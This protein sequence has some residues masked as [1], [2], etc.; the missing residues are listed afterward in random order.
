MENLS[1]QISFQEEKRFLL[2]DFNVHLNNALQ[3]RQLGSF[4]RFQHCL[5]VQAQILAHRI[6]VVCL[7]DIH[8]S[9][10]S[11]AG[12]ESPN[13]ENQ[14]DEQDGKSPEGRVIVEWNAGNDSDV[15]RA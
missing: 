15:I 9:A 7:A 13:D 2:S 3:M 14:Q 8:G 5:K 6:D 1:E 11:E 12:E 10:G 4:F